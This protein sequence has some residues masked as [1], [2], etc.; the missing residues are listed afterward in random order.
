MF[1]IVKSL[2]ILVFVSSSIA[3]ISY[4]F[5]NVSFP[6]IFLLATVI[7]LVLSWFLKTYIIHTQKKA[8]ITRQSQMLSQIE[9]EATEAPCAYCGYTNLIPISPEESNDFECTECGEHNS[10]Y[11]NITVAQKTIPIDSR[12][13]EVTNFNENLQSAKEKLNGSAKKSS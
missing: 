4:T 8:Y 6:G 3:G 11:V 7:Q 9:Q 13:Y 5:L 10:V 1:E 2:T 12:P